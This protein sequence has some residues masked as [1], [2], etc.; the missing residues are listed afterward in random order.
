[1]QFSYLSGLQFLD[2]RGDSSVRAALLFCLLIASSSDAKQPVVKQPVAPPDFAVVTYAVAEYFDS[3]P[4]YQAGDLISRSQIIG[5]IASV[6]DSGWDVPD[7]DAIVELGLA[8]NAFLVTRLSTSA[9]RKFM[10]K[11]AAHPGAYA[12]L[13][14]LSSISRGQT[15]VNDLI[16]KRGGDEL[17]TYLA[18]T[19]HGRQ[20]GEQLAATRNGVDLNK[21]TGRIYTVDDLVAELKHL[22]D[23]M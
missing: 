8:D 6:N 5:A 3:L 4:H 2:T 7:A 17:V 9:G 21:P 15:L 14:R 12:R 16:R 10:R 20:L 19:K 1:V 22:W 11:I 23:K 18:T 13:D